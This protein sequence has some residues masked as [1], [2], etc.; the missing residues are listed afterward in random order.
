MGLVI[1]AVVVAGV[2]YLI[3]KSLSNRSQPSYV[4]PPGQIIYGSDPM[5]GPVG[6]ADNPIADMAVIAA[7]EIGAQVLF[8]AFSNQGPP[9]DT[10]FNGPDDNG[11]N[12]PDFGSGDSFDSGSSDF[13]SGDNFDSGGGFD[14]F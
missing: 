7:E 2:I 10:G 5:Q 12:S 1:F 13:D 8:D 11:Q 3:I 9:I 4:A 14:G 6:L